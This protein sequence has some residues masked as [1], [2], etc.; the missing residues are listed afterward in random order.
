MVFASLSGVIV[1]VDN[2]PLVKVSIINVDMR[3]EVGAGCKNNY[4]TF[5]V[6][7]RL[8]PIPLQCISMVTR[9]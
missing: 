3:R 4:M 5:Y 8:C 6:K 9:C 7:W 2:T 1:P